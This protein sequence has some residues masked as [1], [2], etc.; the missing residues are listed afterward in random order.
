[1]SRLTLLF[2]SALLVSCG[3]PAP[4]PTPSATPASPVAAP[5]PE[6]ATPAEPSLA[7]QLKDA[8]LTL[9]DSTPPPG[10]HEPEYLFG[11]TTRKHRVQVAIDEGVSSY[12]GWKASQTWDETPQ[13]VLGDA[14]ESVVADDCNAKALTFT[15]EGYSY[16]V[17]D[18]GCDRNDSPPPGPWTGKLIVRKG[19]TVISQ[20]DCGPSG[21]MSRQGWTIGWRP[22]YA[23]A[24]REDTKARTVIYQDTEERKDGE[25]VA[26]EMHTLLSVVGPYISYAV[27]YYGEG[28]AHPTYGVLW[29]VVD[30]SMPG[31]SLDLRELFG[32]AEVLQA[33]L[34]SPPVMAAAKEKQPMDVASLIESMDGGCTADFG[35]RMLERFAFHHT[36]NMEVFV[37]VGVS[38]GCEAERGTFTILPLQ[39]TMQGPLVTEV[40]F[41]NEAGAM[42]QVLAP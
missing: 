18:G 36:A 24:V 34:E 21:S 12:K 2:A 15:N 29:K 3:P 9:P 42:M 26:S 27:E 40:A 31:R 22:G 4:A 11:C 38:H 1:M 19:D 33:M 30:I 37:A 7:E 16:E 35:P 25:V 23:D 5:A 6:P 17:R 14:V 20:D 13:L 39:L 28:G 41:A 8:E 10:Y 32:E